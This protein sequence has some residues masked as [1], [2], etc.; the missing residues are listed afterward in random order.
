MTEIWSDI[1]SEFLHL[2]PTG[3]RLLA[4]AGTDAERSRRAAD[5]LAAALTDAG[6]RVE[7]AHTADGDEDALRTEVI[8]PFRADR[9]ERVLVV[10]G[11]ATLLSASA[12]G[13]WNFAVWQLAG[14]EQPHTAA[15][16]IVDV[17]DPAHPHR[18]FA[19]FCALPSAFGA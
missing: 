9:S 6:Q 3:G 16:V 5:D 15:S 2:Y 14:D 8:A 17:T 10:S 11:P 4:V 19:D 18:R 13:L 12:R 1:A 7:R